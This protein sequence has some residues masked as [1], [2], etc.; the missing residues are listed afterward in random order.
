MSG[1]L[2]EMRRSACLLYYMNFTLA[3]MTERREK[4][5]TFSYDHF[6]TD[7]AHPRCSEL[8]SGR[9]RRQIFRVHRDHAY[10]HL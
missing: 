8:R 7:I 6:H 5:Y 4:W 10:I 3:M 9:G 2:I 1:F